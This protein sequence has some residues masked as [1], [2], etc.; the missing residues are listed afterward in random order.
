MK[1]LT[2][3]AKSIRLAAFDVD[4]VFTDG[5]L[6]FLENGSEMKSFHTLDGYGIKMLR[7]ANIDV[8]IISGR[9]SSIVTDRSRNLGIT[10][11]YQGEQDKLKALNKIMLQ[12]NLKYSQVSY[13]GDDLPD[14]ELIQRVGLGM[15][16]PNAV[17]VVKRYAHGITEKKG[18]GGAVRELCELILSSKNNHILSKT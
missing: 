15:A 2:E 4:G 16:V 11:L 7:K 5:R 12:L 18:G 6:Y 17:E 14:L 1:S 13:L 10:H 9:T 8:A 3:R